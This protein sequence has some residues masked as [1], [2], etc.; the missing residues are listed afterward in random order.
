MGMSV[1]ASPSV[2][3]AGTTVGGNFTVTGTETAT[4]LQLTGTT[5]VL[6]TNNSGG[7]VTMRKQVAGSS[8]PGANVAR[9]YLVDG[10]VGG[11]LKLVTRA[12]AAGAETTILDNIPQ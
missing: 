8:P 12:G 6:D 5:V 3:P 2:L 11:T 9:L 1:S 10:T 7:Q 4:A